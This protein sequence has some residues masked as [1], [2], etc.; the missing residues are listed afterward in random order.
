MMIPKTVIKFSGK[1]FLL[2]GLLLSSFPDAFAQQDIQ[3]LNADSVNQLKLDGK[4]SGKEYFTNSRARVS[5]PI[6]SASSISAPPPTC[7]CWIQ[8]D[9]T[10][11][12]GAFDGSGAS[13]GPGIPPLYRNDDWSTLPIALPFDFCFYGTP[14]NSLYLNNNGNVSIGAPYSTFTATAFPNSS[15]VMIAPFWGDVDTRDTLSGLVYYKLTPTSMIIQWENVGYFSQYSDKLNTFQLILTDGTDPIL[16]S[17]QNV[18][19]CYKDM[20]WTTGDASGGNN[21]F[22]GT[23]ATV[24]VNR[25]NG[26]DYIQVGL[27]DQPGG[28]Y[29]G[30]FGNNDGIDALD[31]QSFYFNSCVS[32]SNVAPLAT[33]IQV[34][35]TVKLCCND[36]I[37]LYA[38]FLSPEQNQ[39][40]TAGVDPNG[41]SG[42]S[43]LNST[44]GNTA[45]I[46]V[47]VV[48]TTSNIGYHTIYIT[49]T[50]NGTPPLTNSTPV[51]LQVMP[52]PTTSFTFTPP[53]PVSPGTTVTFTNTTVGGFSF[54]W[55]F[56]DGSPTSTLTHPTHTYVNGGTYVVTLTATG[57][58][59][60]SSTASNT[61]S[62]SACS[63][64]AI[65]VTDTVCEGAAAI[66]T[67][68][69]IA[70]PAA[71][72]NWNFGS[73][74]I[75]SGSGAGPYS[76]S[77][78][79]PGNQNVYL[80]LN[81]G[82][83][84]PAQA[85]MPVNVVAIPNAEISTDTTLCTGEQSQIIFSGTAATNASFSWNLGNSTVISG[86]GTASD[87][88]TVQWN[89]VGT[90]SI[91]LTVVQNGCSDSG[92]EV[93]EV[94][95]IPGSGFSVQASVCAG[96]PVQIDYT[97][98]AM[99]SADYTWNFD[100]GIVLSGSGQGPYQVSWNSPGTH[101]ISL[102]VIQDACPSVQ[103]TL[104]I[105]V[106]ALPVADISADPDLCPGEQ[107]NISFSGSADPGAVYNWNLGNGMLISG[108]GAGPL[109]ASWSQSGS[110]SISLIV[111]QNG[112][113]DTGF[114]Q[115]LIYPTPSS[116]FTLIPEACTEDTVQLTY[117][118]NT[119]LTGQF[120]WDFNGASVISGNSTGPYFLKWTTAGI[121]N[122]SLTVSE[123]GC[124]SPVTTQVI[125]IHDIP[126]LNAGPDTVICSGTSVNIGLPGDPA[127]NYS[128]TPI[129]G[130]SDPTAA[131]T[132][133]SGSNNSSQSEI[134]D[135]ILTAISPVGCRNRDT[136]SV[137]INPVPGVSFMRP[138]PQCLE[139]NSFQ[140]SMNNL[141][142][143]GA[144]YEWNFG[145]LANPASS[146]SAFP[147]AVTYP[148]AG[149]YPVT[150]SASF[151][152]CVAIPY[153]DSVTV[154]PNP[155]ADFQPLIR[156]GCVPLMV[157]FIN[158]SSGD[159][160]TYEWSF[161]DNSS[162]T[163]VS[164]QHLFTNPGTYT[165]NLLTRDR[166]GCTDYI[167]YPD[168]IKVYP[169][170]QPGFTPSPQSA[171]ILEPMI[172]F[173]N[174]TSGINQYFWEFGDGSS[175]VLVNPDH[176]YNET[177]EYTVTLYATNVYGCLDSI[178][179]KVRIEDTFT[180]YIPNTFTP[181]GDG[182]ND[183]FSGF[184]T[185]LK[186]YQM[187]ILD[188]WGLKIYSTNDINMPWDG[189]VENPVQAD[190]YV[191]RIEIK[192]N[193]DKSYVYTG[194]VNVIR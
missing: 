109:I 4:L 113:Q 39:I 25:G 111:E 121:K 131:V 61:I 125:N 178:T 38:E 159:G 17:G 177:G 5:Q 176:L 51:I 58:N 83:C 3:H 145:P 114:F 174:S 126:A 135:F 116:A 101:Q 108:S 157:P 136:V 21:G 104:P 7:D 34:C 118:G 76:I 147:P 142:I 8:R 140:F 133:F 127:L 107:N 165:V 156:E 98:N 132:A 163:S 12:I 164:A 67:F 192:D 29:D 10:W 60:C 28:T 129:S 77:W 128:W 162:D 158:L 152:N 100:G 46:T 6:V 80:T 182:R 168:L 53:M 92:S 173:I 183:Y 18:S 73:G 93:I 175:S 82:S 26:T 23:P 186:S 52:L 44:S 170:P 190:V 87:P 1:I 94:F 14:V 153:S 48:G 62:V 96:T 11:Q 49:G 45:S 117:I 79:T 15:F 37:Q 35:D 75:L 143:A 193:N 24:G 47:Q 191:Y 2:C 105:N 112:C 59:G 148:Q 161:S 85:S 146:T 154:V 155:N 63:M 68:T 69:G 124:P 89:T 88:Y 43:I 130:L 22:G 189:T 103:T 187:D 134:R 81:D 106:T 54:V 188:R 74:T 181:N 138:A 71:S 122:I 57:P 95:P 166:A 184:G 31:F 56:G 120:N 90:D 55:D 30:P 13:G 36:T 27:F 78:N 50:D 115:I 65:T 139:N 99:A 137:R 123:N 179:A 110:D 33:A 40:T 144:S 180:F 91:S 185:R 172:Q 64:A 102:N 66:V 19:F 141:V 169:L 97:G 119:G 167:S 16:P 86:T 41:M 171:S 84:P 194:H 72:Y 9:A 70:S 32:S 151:G 20:Q 149:T 150:L 42:V 160:N